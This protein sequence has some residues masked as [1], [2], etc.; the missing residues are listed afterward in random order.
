MNGCYKCEC[1][2]KNIKKIYLITPITEICLCE[3]CYYRLPYDIQKKVTEG[4][5]EFNG[6]M[7]LAFKRFGC[8]EMNKEWL[9]LVKGEF[10]YFRSWTKTVKE[11]VKLMTDKVK[12]YGVYHEGRELKNETVEKLLSKYY[13][14]INKLRALGN[15]III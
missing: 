3:R 4:D 8:R 10:K 12:V 13:D 7:I 5:V 14:R 2:V 6:V 11:I 15:Q 9:I 1:S